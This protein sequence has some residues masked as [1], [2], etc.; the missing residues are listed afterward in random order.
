M[1]RIN[2]FI[3]VNIPK[4]YSA[5]KNIIECLNTNSISSEGKFVKNLKIIFLS[6]I[7]E[8]MVAVLVELRL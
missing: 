8:N 1:S 2:Y 4:L 7:Q 5:E 3:P 6:I